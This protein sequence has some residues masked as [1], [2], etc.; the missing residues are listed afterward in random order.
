MTVDQA[1]DAMLA[2]FKAYWD[3]V[4]PAVVAVYGDVPAP[5]TPSAW[6]RVV[7]RHAT[8]GQSSLTGGLGT[9]KYESRGTLWIQVFAPVGDG[10]VRAYA[11][12][13]GVVNAYRNA[14]IDV[15]FRNVRMN[16]V[17]TS[18]AFEQINVL[19]DFEYET[20]L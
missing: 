9:T 11:L 13:E 8:G 17:G 20:I 1:R 6:A 4:L 14:K 18:G 7:V 5:T 2:I 10:M 12:A 16:E 19:V 3:A 15:W